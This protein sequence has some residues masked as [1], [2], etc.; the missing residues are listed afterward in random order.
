[1]DQQNSAKR[2]ILRIIVTE[3]RW[4]STNFFTLWVTTMNILGLIAQ[5]ILPSIWAMFCQVRIWLMNLMSLP[6]ISD[7]AQ[8]KRK[9]YGTDTGIKASSLRS[10]V[11]PLSW[12]HRNKFCA[13]YYNLTHYKHILVPLPLLFLQILNLK[14]KI[15][16]IKQNTFNR[17]YAS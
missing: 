9:W 10:P 16:V 8:I 5:I 3:W 12:S 4:L 13:H 7:N 1:M 15:F 6:C 17:F 14:R 2:W 11:I